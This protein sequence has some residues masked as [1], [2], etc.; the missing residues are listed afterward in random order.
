MGAMFVVPLLEPSRDLRFIFQLS[1]H[2]FQERL[3][4]CQNLL[5]PRSPGH[6]P[7]SKSVFALK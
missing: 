3:A 5:A 4:I 1:F 6:A 2:R 7:H